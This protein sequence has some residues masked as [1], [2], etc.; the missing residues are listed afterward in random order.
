MHI[1]I[2][3]AGGVG[4]YFGAKLCRHNADVSFIARGDHLRAIRKNGITVR[5]S[6]EGVIACRPS[7]VTDDVSDLPP[8]DV[9][10][11]CVKSYDLT[12]ILG[13][14]NRVV[15]E[16]TIMIPLLNGIDI[17]D[18]VRAIIQTGIVLPACVYIGT[19]IVEPGVVSQEGGACKILFGPDPEHPDA[20]METISTLFDRSRVKYDRLNDGYPA[21]WT[22]F[23]FIASFGLVTGCF[24]K[25][26][27]QVMESEELSGYVRSIME[28]IHALARA[29]GIL[30]PET[31]VSDSYKKGNDFPFETK[32]SFQRD[33]EIR[34]KNDERDLFAGTIIRM[35]EKLQIQTPV[36]QEISDR[37]NEQKPGGN[38][39]AE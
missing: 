3:G 33:F 19:H 30:L 6:S 8:L 37:I 13:K 15:H 25:T 16:S 20:S 18:R 26:L 29:K 12:P 35:G 11:I 27:G 31:I 2:I 39:K 22:K 38:P 17:C 36:V 28:E 21:V 24:S 32:T 14:L 23:I 7:I 5:T 1:G 10:L 9:C 4:G 34:D